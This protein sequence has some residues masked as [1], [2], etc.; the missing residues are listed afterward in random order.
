MNPRLC[1]GMWACITDMG[2]LTFTRADS[3]FHVPPTFLLQ[4]AAWLYER[5]LDHVRAQMKKVGGSTAPATFSLENTHT[6]VGG[7][8]MKRLGSGGSG[9]SSMVS[10]VDFC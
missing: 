7:V 2:L 6:T 9:G 8:S 1:Y 10:L 5:H 3:F 4:Q